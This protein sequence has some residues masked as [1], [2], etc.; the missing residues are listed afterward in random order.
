MHGLVQQEEEVVLGL[1]VIW[2]P[3]LGAAS[4][5]TRALPI[6]VLLVWIPKASSHP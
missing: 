6:R 1:V 3:N 2:L 5:R 4:S